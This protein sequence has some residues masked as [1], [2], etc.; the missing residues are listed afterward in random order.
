MGL[1]SSNTRGKTC[2]FVRRKHGEPGAG[3]LV[4]LGR[5]QSPKGDGATSKLGE[6]A[7]ELG[8]GGVVGE[9]RHV[10]NLAALRKE[11]PDVGSGIHGAG[12]HIR[13]LVRRLGLANQTAENASQSDSLLHGTA[14][15]SRGQGL[16]VERE[17][18][19]DGGARLHGLH[20]ESR[21]DVGQRRGPKGKRLGMVL[22]PSLVLLAEVEGA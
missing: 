13:V 15:R 5:A 3:R 18:M 9:T 14:R 21:T 8:L 20:L 11:S 1:E 10:Q 4:L 12:E 22:L 17:V 16:Q 6:P 2:L 7:L 19:L